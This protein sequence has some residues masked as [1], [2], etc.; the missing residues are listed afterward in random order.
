[1]NSGNSYNSGQNCI[2][3]GTSGSINVTGNINQQNN[4]SDEDEEYDDE[5]YDEE[6]END[7][8]LENE[9]APSTDLSSV[10]TIIINSGTA[11]IILESES[12]NGYQ[13][14]VYCNDQLDVYTINNG[15]LTIDASSV[16]NPVTIV[17]PDDGEEIISVAITSISGDIEIS[18][19]KAEN[20]SASSTSGDLNINVTTKKLVCS[21]VSG[22][23]DIYHNY[24]DNGSGIF[25]SVSGDIQYHV[26]GVKKMKLIAP[27]S[28]DNEFESDEDGYNASVNIS[29]VSGDVTIDNI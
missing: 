2:V 25:S 14:N 27:A 5:D 6:Y 18:E 8:E 20:V 19:I 15:V 13:P 4:Y 23:L 1:V 11:D 22:D 24:Q 21:S 16:S 26:S 29:T 12:V 17:L 28:C 10:N 3:G 7:E 9:S